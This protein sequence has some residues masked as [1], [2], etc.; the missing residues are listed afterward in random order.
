MAVLG[1]SLIFQPV[2]ASLHYTQTCTY[3]N[4]TIITVEG[5][6]DIT[7]FSSKLENKTK[8]KIYKKKYIQKICKK[9]S[10]FG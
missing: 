5:K 4:D 8:K 3:K 2:F 1:H 7:N 10:L 9:K 6:H